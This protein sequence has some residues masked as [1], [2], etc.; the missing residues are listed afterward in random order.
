L[1]GAGSLHPASGSLASFGQTHRAVGLAW[2]WL[3]SAKRYRALELGSFG[4]TD[5]RGPMLLRS[6]RVAKEPGFAK[7]CNP[8]IVQGPASVLRF[9]ETGVV[10]C[11]EMAGLP[12][13]FPDYEDCGN[14]DESPGS[15]PNS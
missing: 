12:P 7:V 6:Y 5:D 14:V 4:Q 15:V 2:I 3:C 9:G 8:I 13:V 10:S 1:F 11:L